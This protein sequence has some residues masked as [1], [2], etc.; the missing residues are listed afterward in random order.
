MKTLFE[1]RW[2]ALL[3]CL[4]F[5]IAVIFLASTAYMVCKEYNITAAQI[6]KVILT[7]LALL[8]IYKVIKAFKSLFPDPED[9]NQ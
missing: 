8:F 9:P 1:N 4:I 3:G 5:T 7:A 6:G 2:M